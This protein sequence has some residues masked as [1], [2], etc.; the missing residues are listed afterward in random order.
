MNLQSMKRQAVPLHAEVA[1][2][3][4]HQIMSGELK[5]GEKLPALSALTEQL[6]V[7]RMTVV[8]AMNALEEEGLIERHSGRGTFVR[9]VEL[10][11]RAT[12]HMKAELSQLQ[13][14]VS[15]LEVSV[16]DGDTKVE[17]SDA[18]GRQYRS[19]KRIHAKD[20]KPFCFVD[21]QLDNTIFSK[22]PSRFSKEIVVSVLEDMSIDVASARQKVTISYADFE[23]AQAL[24]INVNSAVFRVFREFFDAGGALIY[25]ATLIYPGDFLELEIEFAVDGNST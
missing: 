14:M 18:D 23:L 10:P 3:L 6:G 7:A 13:S 2:V 8:Q 22:S 25:S 17:T 1:G 5:S 21:L 24:G 9:E 16:L 19:M 20:G 4:R 11:E 15:Q 12:L